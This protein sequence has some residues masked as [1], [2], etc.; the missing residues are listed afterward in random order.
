M[1]IFYHNYTI[2]FVIKNKYIIHMINILMID[3]NNYYFFVGK[4]IFNPMP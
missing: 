1:N 4:K 2:L 3:V